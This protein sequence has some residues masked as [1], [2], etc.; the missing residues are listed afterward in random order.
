[1]QA[2]TLI[3]SPFSLLVMLVQLLLSM[4]LSLFFFSLTE[5]PQTKD[6]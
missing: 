6:D 5:K 3:H 2:S 1:M 4:L